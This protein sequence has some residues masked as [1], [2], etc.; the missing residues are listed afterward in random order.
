MCACVCVCMCRLEA[1]LVFP[2]YYCRQ[3]LSLKASMLMGL[4]WLVSQLQGSA[5]LW[6]LSRN[7]RCVPPNLGCDMGGYGYKL[8]GYGMLR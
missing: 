6:L 2:T 8:H 7:H 1:D 5:G 4:R 3:G